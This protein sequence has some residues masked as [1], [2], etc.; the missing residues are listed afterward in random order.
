MKKNNQSFSLIQSGV[1]FLLLSTKKWVTAI[2]FIALSSFI[3]KGQPIINMDALLYS[4]VNGSELTLKDSYVPG[5]VYQYTIQLATGINRSDV[6]FGMAPDMCG[7]EFSFIDS[8]ENAGDFTITG[9]CVPNAGATEIRIEVTA[10]YPTVPDPQ[11]V[12]LIIPISRIPVKV[13][14]V[15]DISGSMGGNAHNST[16]KRWDV[17]KRAVIG[18][19]QLFEEFPV[20]GDVGC[21]T[22]FTTDTIQPHSPILKGFIP[23]YPPLHLPESE[24]YSKRIEKDMG[25]PRGPMNMT[26]MG[27]GLKDGKSK[28]EPGSD[29]LRKSVVLFTDGL[30]NISPKVTAGGNMLEDNTY[31]NDPG[32]TDPVRYIPIAIL[33]AET[34][35]IILT[36]MAEAS[37]AATGATTAIYKYTNGAEAVNWSTFFQG[38]LTEITSGSSP[39]IVFR[40]ETEFG[41]TETIHE[42]V[43]N[44][45]IAKL[46]VRLEF[47]ANAALSMRLFRDSTDLTSLTQKISGSFY[48][49]LSIVFPATDKRKIFTPE[50][51]WSIQITG[52]QT[53]DYMIVGIADDHFLDYDCR[54]NKA[55]FTVGDTLQ[56]S[57][58]LTYS[59]KPLTDP[60]N[61][62]MALILRPGE[63]I[64]DLLA[65][66]ATPVV[67]DTFDVSTPAQQKL[68][69]LIE[70]DT[71]FCNALK[72]TKQLVTLVQS[73]TGIYTGTFKSTELT[74]V[75]R[76]NFLMKG[77]IPG[78]GRF[79]RLE[80]QDAYFKFGQTDPKASEVGVV[81]DTTTSPAV[82]YSA[83]VTI[84]PIN[85]YGKYLG[86]GFDTRVNVDVKKRLSLLNPVWKPVKLI[87]IKSKS[88]LQGD[89]ILM[90]NIGDNLDGSYNIVLA[91]IPKNTDP[92]I[93]IS[94]MGE[95]LREGRLSQIC[96][97]DSHEN[98]WFIIISILALLLLIIAYIKKNRIPK[99][100][101]WLIVI[102]W[103]L[104]MILQKAGIINTISSSCF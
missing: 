50:G 62:I 88:D 13:A 70:T 3:I 33:A 24:L 95:V 18:F 39:E 54:L 21:L 53:C 38:V 36:D 2:L 57:V 101:I 97:T 67:H 65:R 82:G 49:Q 43:L 15:L 20:D 22:Y 92:V 9:S 44:R 77:S 94:V 60:S 58:N 91:N 72:A 48:Q 47:P 12:I 27:K 17:L 90:T 26:A 46:V 73:D 14:L 35:P 16:E 100:L 61:N 40:E 32:T 34:M 28:L 37:R 71:A 86:P 75:Y 11:D 80:E 76:V 42:F 6:Q 64:G 4:D 59:G 1:L 19:A 102:I 7:S 30:Q 25:P 85:R 66:T 74:G 84:K 10:S 45:N 23:V 83:T 93:R 81:K 104:I 51:K 78:K 99:W 98:L 79:E 56:M 5:T 63:D 29:P 69:N 68:V 52:G 87:H 31:L 103:I 41:G 96:K 89:T 8:G 55:L